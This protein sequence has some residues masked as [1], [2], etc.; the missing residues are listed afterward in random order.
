MTRGAPKLLC[1]VAMTCAMA[2]A[3][4]KQQPNAAGGQMQPETLGPGEFGNAVDEGEPAKHIQTFDTLD[5][6][7]FSNQ[8]WDRLS[9]SHSDD[10]DVSWPDGHDTHGIQRHIEDLKKLFIHAP[11]TAI[12]VHPIRIANGDWTAVTGVMTGTFTKPMPMADGSVVQPTGK[13]FSLPMATIG[14]W[15]NGKMD[16]EWLYWDN[17]TYMSQLGIGK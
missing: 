11:D 10:I 3:A 2:F 12:K 5:F 17:A 8:K 14:H 7:A 1:L 6:D 15:K 13:K 4:C 16:H 9:E